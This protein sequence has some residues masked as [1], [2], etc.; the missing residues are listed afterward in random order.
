MYRSLPAHG[1]VEKISRLCSIARGWLSALTQSF[2]HI[3]AIPSLRT[4]PSTRSVLVKLQHRAQNIRD[5]KPP[6]GLVL[7]THRSP[8][9]LHP[10][11]STT[12]SHL[13]HLPSL[14]RPTQPPPHP[15]HP[16]IAPHRRTSIEHIIRIPPRL[17][18]PQAIVV[19]AIECGFPIWVEEVALQQKRKRG[20]QSAFFS[21]DE[22]V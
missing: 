4:T 18:P 21:N 7:D 5:L 11:P 17:D 10:I 6:Y 8:P 2:E 15:K 13:P 1:I 19:G 20:Q 22:G 3:P 16:L 14:S 12:P 9:N